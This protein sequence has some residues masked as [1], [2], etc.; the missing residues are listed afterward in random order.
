MLCQFSF[1]NFKSFKDEN[2]L[3][4]YAEPI[5]EHKESLIVDKND[6]ESFLPVAVLYGPNGGGKSNTLE[7]IYYLFLSVL[8]KV[9]AARS[10]NNAIEYDVKNIIA[11]PKYHIF[12]ENCKKEPMKFEILFREDDETFKYKLFIL[13]RK[14]VE[15]DLY[16]KKTT[17]KNVEIIFE[18]KNGLIQKGDII[19][20]VFSNNI[21][22]FM[23]FLSYLA[24]N[25]KI[26][27]IEKVIEWFFKSD[28]LNYANPM[29]DVQIFVP[30]NKK[31][32]DNMFFMLNAM[33]INATGARIVKNAD[34]NIVD[35]YIKHKKQDG[36][37]VEIPLSE[38]SAGT[39]K[40]FSF[41]AR[42]LQA[43][44]D[45]KFVVVDELDAKLHPKLLQYIIELFTNPNMNKKGAQ[46]LFT[47]HDISTMNKDVFRRD[48]I[49]FCALN[50]N[51]A[52]NLYSLTSFRKP[53]GKIPRKDESYGKQYLEG[54]YGADPY[55]RKILQW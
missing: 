12:D 52:S 19:K 35:I 14:I 49:W 27:V 32:R 2:I 47:S 21:S 15:E 37:V 17:D 54:K 33:G 43:L 50:P 30:N 4:F 45:G 48:E 20:E 23:P 40:V 16:Y 7:A 28:F 46:L 3:D 25:Y 1:E 41:L 38:E 10:L 42:L 36:S 6:N 22:D 5:T 55:L 13:D 26:P 39:I 18:R 11:K 29:S 53:N 24:I 51:N 34:N 8:N 44:Q 9:I 31:A